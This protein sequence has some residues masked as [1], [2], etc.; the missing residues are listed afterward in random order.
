MRP[1]LDALSDDDKVALALEHARLAEAARAR[2]RA[3]H[4]RHRG[5]RKQ[6]ARERRALLRLAAKWLVRSQR[7]GNQ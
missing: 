6:S 3:S 5:E 1:I 4:A 7:G 2:A